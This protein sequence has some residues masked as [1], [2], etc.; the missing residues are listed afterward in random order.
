MFKQE[1]IYCCKKLRLSHNLA[2][3]AQTTDGASHQ[4]YLY[5]LLS[6]ELKNR[7]QGR[8]SKLIKGAGFYNIKTLGFRFDEIPPFR[9]YA[10]K[11]EIFGF[12]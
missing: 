9:S 10:R 11:P 12:H 2:D 4:E 1:I 3:M 7:E 5:K 8:I 6:A